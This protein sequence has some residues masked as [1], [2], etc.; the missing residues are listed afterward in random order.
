MPLGTVLAMVL[1]ALWALWVG[2]FFLKMVV[3]IR[4]EIVDWVFSGI[5]IHA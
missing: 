3:F 4:H 5:R 1:D 2:V